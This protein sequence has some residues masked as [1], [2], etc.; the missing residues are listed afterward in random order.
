M[1]ILIVE[2]DDFARDASA[3]YL[4][5]LGHEVRAAASPDEAVR[6]A[7]N[8]CPDVV[9]CDWMLGAEE[10]GTDVARTLQRRCEAPIIFVTAQPLARLRARTQDLRVARYL[11]KPISLSLLAAALDDLSPTS[12]DGNRQQKRR[13]PEG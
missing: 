5:H 13:H 11:R 9:I 10:D 7:Q 6:H 8:G 2:D 1:K 4:D 12:S 3:R